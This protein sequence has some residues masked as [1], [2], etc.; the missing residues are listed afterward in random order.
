MRVAKLHPLFRPECQGV[1]RERDLSYDEELGESGLVDV[2]RP[3]AAREGHAFGGPP[4]PVVF[5]VHGGGF[6]FMSKDTHVVMALGFARRGC[7]VVVPNYRLAPRHPYPAAAADVCRAFV[8]MTRQA[9]AIGA[10]LSRL[11]LAGESAG[12]NLATSL[13]VALSYERPEPFAKEAFATGLTPR[14]LSAA[15]GIFQA[16][17]LRRLVR[18]SPT[19]PP[20]IKSRL[21]QIEDGYFGAHNLHDK[22]LADPV[23]VLERGD[24]P[25]RPFP[26]VFL[27]IGT[28]DPLLPDTKRMRRALAQRGIAVR[29]K[30]YPGE[31]H[32]FHA[33]AFRKAAKECWDDTFAF[34]K[35]HV[36]AKATG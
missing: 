7:V 9:S 2:Y 35:E 36:P 30:Y 17:D 5:Y 22:D 32:G 24:V 19:M 26:P 31:I 10:D 15:C 34:L 28:R 11:V 33:L 8:W 6:R 16:T 29:A 3:E 13:A 18:R 25:A 4:W 23:C 27:P 20:W 12:A 1:V 14:A 21:E